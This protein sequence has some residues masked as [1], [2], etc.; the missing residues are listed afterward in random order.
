MTE[1]EINKEVQTRVEFKM[2]EFLEGVKN[3]L[4]FKYGQAFDMTRKSN[5]AWL[6]F[7][8]V[9][10]MISKEIHMPTPYDSMSE[11]NRREAKNKAV[12][13]IMKSLNL[14]GKDVDY[15]H[16]LRSVVAGVEMGQKY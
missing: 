14:Q 8:E 15:N 6:A 2:N 12:D 1:L 3:R 5:K 16:I 4:A 9:S 13:K 10:E 7:K 11:K